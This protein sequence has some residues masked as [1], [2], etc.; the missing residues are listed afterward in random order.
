[1]HLK[2]T[3]Y[4]LVQ[5]WDEAPQVADG[6]FHLFTALLSEKRLHTRSLIGVAHLP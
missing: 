3:L 2:K 1:M 4:L 6:A 5:D